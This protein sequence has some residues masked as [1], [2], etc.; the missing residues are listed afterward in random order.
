MIRQLCAVFVALL[1][2]T[3]CGA[4]QPPSTGESPRASAAAS[5]TASS[6]AASAAASPT[7][8]VV[9]VR[10]FSYEPR[11]ITVA[12]G[13]TVTWR[14]HDQPRHDVATADRSIRSEL[15]TAG[16]EYS[17]TFTTPGTYD[18]LCTVHQYMTGTVVVR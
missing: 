18:Y 3:A 16:Q 15:L 10:N 12:V 13:T 5:P 6:Q 17:H 14:F 9:D 7:A 2:V 11:T 8:A 1:A 4:T